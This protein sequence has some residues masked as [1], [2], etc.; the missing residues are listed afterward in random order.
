MPQAVVLSSALLA[1]VHLQLCFSC[2]RFVGRGS[3]APKFALWTR[4]E[5]Q[6]F[7]SRIALAARLVV[8]T[9]L[10]SLS[11]GVQTSRRN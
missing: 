2:K 1:A 10:C 8:N 3:I 4:V 9:A 7:I 6:P 5:W 11:R